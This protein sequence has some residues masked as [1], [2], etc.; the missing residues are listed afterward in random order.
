M[1]TST[2]NLRKYVALRVATA[3][4]LSACGG[5]LHA[6]GAQGEN[7]SYLPAV[8]LQQL[9]QRIEA[10]KTPHPRL[11]ANR[12]TLAAIRRKTESDPLARSIAD[13]VVQQATGMRNEKPVSRIMQGKRLLAQSRLCLKRVTTL[14]MAYHLTGN[15]LHASRCQQE[16][17]AAARF[18]DWNPS[19]FLD[20]AEMT[21]ALALGYDWLYDQLDDQA[22]R[23][24][25]QAIVRK[26][27][28]LPLTHPMGWQRSKNNWGQVCHAG[29]VAGALAVMEDEPER[30]ARTLHN[31]LRNVTYSMAAYAPHGSYPEGP[32]YWAYGTGFNGLLIGVLESVLGTDFGLSQAPGFSETGQFPSLACGPTSLFFNFCD[33]GDQRVPQPILFWF[34]ARYQRPDW[35]LGEYDLL[36]RQVDTLLAKKSASAGGRLLPLVL[37]WLVPKPEQEKIRMPLNWSSEGI[38]PITV[39]RSAWS[40]REATYVGVKGGSPSANHGHMD[41]GSFVLDADGQRW[42]MDLGAEGYHKIESLGMSLWERGQDSDRWTI[43]RLNSMG[44]NTLMIDGQLQ[45]ADGHGQVISFSDQ[46]PFSHTVVDMSSVYQGQAESVRRGFALLPTREVL[47]QDEL[48]GLKP[49]SQVR[50]A[51]ITRAVAESLGQAKV[52]LRQADAQLTMHI[53]NPNRMVWQEVDTATPRNSWDSPNPG[54]RMLA[55]EATAPQTGSLTLTVLATPGQKSSHG[56]WVPKPLREWGP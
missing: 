23:E 21:F 47:I 51:M 46:L 5:G 6:A 16:M 15:Q 49:G 53:V 52:E 48:T 1:K 12:E 56:E 9:R 18:R 11:L 2:R 39:H 40:D 38:T 29:M 19:H 3:L 7:D 35:L 37:L 25:R 26:G 28:N 14:A 45:R 54:T 10:C 41:I 33:G 43:F 30:A 44:H 42:A 34:A 32:G 17:L 31:G 55:F 22:R 24:I 4:V 13:L 8:T 20:V 50:W 27:V 36:Q